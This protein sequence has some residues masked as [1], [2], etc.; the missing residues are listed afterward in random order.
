MDV[1]AHCENLVREADKDRF[2][3]SLFAPAEGRRD[4]F[5]L[6]AFNAEVAG[7]QDKV[8]EPLA[9]EIRLQ[10]W[11][12]LVAGTGEPGANPV[13]AALLEIVKRH[14]LPRQPL[15]ELLEARRFDLYEET[16]STRA[17]LEN[18]ASNTSSAVIEL[19]MRILDQPS[20]ATPRLARSAG[21]GYAIAGLARSFAFHASRGKIFVPDEILTAHGAARADILAGRSTIELRDALA[22]F[23][24]QARRHLDQI[25]DQLAEVPDRLVPAL[26]PVALVDPYLARMERADYEPFRTVVEV[27]QWRKQ[28]LLWRAARSPRRIAAH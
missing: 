1:F 23:R 20:G 3:A 24:E 12:D 11:H 2:L 10:Y 27:P 18:Y 14:A 15:L 22:D 19:A 21:I 5:A 8:R 16:F 25:G 6:Y 4:L 13:A 26:L 9:G 28:W 17:D 7:V